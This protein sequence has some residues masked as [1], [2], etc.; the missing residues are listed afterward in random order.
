MYAARSNPPELQDEQA[1]GGPIR[2]GLAVDTRNS[3]MFRD[4]HYA[5]N[6][7]G[8]ISNGLSPRTRPQHT[9]HRSASI[10]SS[11][12]SAYA[13][14]T[15][16]V[17]PVTAWGLMANGGQ[18][19]GSQASPPNYGR[20]VR[21]F[22]RAQGDGAASPQRSAVGQDLY[23]TPPTA[24]R[25]SNSTAVSG[26]YSA[27]AS[28]RHS[29]AEFESYNERSIA[30]TFG[31]DSQ[32]S[33]PNYDD[34]SMHAHT[35]GRDAMLA[36][37]HVMGRNPMPLSASARLRS[38]SGAQDI[39]TPETPSGATFGGQAQRHS[40]VNSMVSPNTRAR[41]IEDT[42][43]ALTG[44]A[45]R[46]R[47]PQAAHDEDRN[48]QRMQAAQTWY[49]VQDTDRARD[50]TNNAH[51]AER[52]QDTVSDTFAWGTPG[53]AR[54]SSVAHAGTSGRPHEQMRGNG[55]AID[56]RHRH[57]AS[58][59]GSYTPSAIGSS[60]HRA[61]HTIGT[62]PVDA[63]SSIMSAS[64]R[65]TRP[66]SLQA[67]N[68]KTPIRSN[69]F[70]KDEMMSDSD[71]KDQDFLSSDEEDFDNEEQGYGGDMVSQQ[72]LIQKQQRVIYDLNLQCKMLV[73]AVQSNADRPVQTL[74]DNYARTCA[75]NRR[76][77]RE[78]EIRRNESE[79]LKEKCAA[80]ERE[81]ANRQGGITEAEHE[82]VAQL[83]DEL[84]AARRSLDVEAAVTKQRMHLLEDKDAR[85]RELEEEL[86][87]ERL[88]SDHWHRNAM[89]LKMSAAKPGSDATASV[90]PTSP[91]MRAGTTTTSETMT[92]RAP[93]EASAHLPAHA[94][95]RLREMNKQND[96]L[97]L[98]VLKQ[99]EELKQA[100]KKTREYEDQ[101]RAVQLEL[102]RAQASHRALDTASDREE[103]A[104]LT[105]DNEA[106][107]DKCDALQRQ[108]NDAHAQAQ[109]HAEAALAAA[110]AIDLDTSAADVAYGSAAQRAEISKLKL[111]SRDAEQRA[112]LYEGN[113]QRLAEELEAE[114]EKM[115]VLCHDYL[116][117]HLRELTVGPAQ[118]ESV[119]DHVRRWSQL[120]VVVSGDQETTPT[121]RM[122]QP[123]GSL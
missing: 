114:R 79:E 71:L 63:N 62:R 43:N 53:R 40:R 83:Q 72:K 74:A 28:R 26:A 81:L 112:R 32:F 6:G 54:T 15:A 47:V 38:A 44:G 75:S 25:A 13:R 49:G 119:Y 69:R 4:R 98:R 87:R 7:R 91:R 117:P 95:Q 67:K 8:D 93:S 51:G 34:P 105:N 27:G 80:L 5:D 92:L 18:R 60:Q 39:L 52:A 77:N 103:I 42:R 96:D 107:N 11:V 97:K 68:G 19:A 78:L 50:T 10:A 118:A 94:E 17:A 57:R 86:A 84:E 101:R 113:A 31:L 106:L 64:A 82:H 41:A 55:L 70:Y 99:E 100:R 116:R 122:S 48:A 46:E 24:H 14:G 121:K 76:A 33:R 20:G 59:T 1:H 123:N 22:G 88:E 61:R 36:A 66:Q 111:E 115:R 16:E 65:R 30:T 29:Q 58:Y 109:S 104:I 3:S 89:A 9:G 45:R 90:S 108:L 21:H 120:K 56:T 23:T 2:N 110:S 85:I 102:K 73:T 12:H 37:T 35:P